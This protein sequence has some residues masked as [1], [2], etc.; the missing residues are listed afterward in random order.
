MPKLLRY[1]GK[2]L[3]DIHFTDWLE[4]KPVALHQIAQKWFNAIKHSGSETE[5]IFHDNYPIVC[6]DSA[7]FAYINVFTSHVNLGFFYG[8]YLP[9]PTGLL[10]GSGKHMRHIKLR[11][12]VNHNEKEVLILLECAYADILQRLIT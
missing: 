1:T 8:A 4:Q 6:V 9:D 12:G 7:P 10:E 11:P 5:D 2:D 3:Q